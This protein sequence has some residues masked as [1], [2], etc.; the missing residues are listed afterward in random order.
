MPTWDGHW[1]SGMLVRRRMSFI[2]IARRAVTLETLLFA[3]SAG[4]NGGSTA[5]V[6][7]R[8]RNTDAGQF[9]RLPKLALHEEASQIQFAVLENK[10]S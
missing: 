2:P 7:T 3:Y 4:A 8:I 9:R 5:R 6:R 10:C 1:P